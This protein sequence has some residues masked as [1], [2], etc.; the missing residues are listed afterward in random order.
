MAIKPEIDN[1]ATLGENLLLVDITKRFKT[2][3]NMETGKFEKTK[4][5][6]H[7]Y[8]I[9]CLEKKFDKFDVKI[10][11]K[12]PLFPLGENGKAVNIPDQCYVEFENLKITPYV[13]DG[14]IQLSANSGKC[15]QLPEE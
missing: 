15:I 10:E 7:V 6:I 12:T 13:R 5:F 1:V 3:E 9:V 14:W 4:E 2:V 8:T 11:E